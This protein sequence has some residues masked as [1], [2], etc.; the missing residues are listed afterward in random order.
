MAQFYILQS[1]FAEL[2]VKSSEFDEN[3]WT[4]IFKYDRVCQISKKNR[5]NCNSLITVVTINRQLPE[6]ETRG[7]S[8][9]G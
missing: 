3:E 7:L 1:N 5:Q 6:Q 9:H 8:T 2:S 4:C